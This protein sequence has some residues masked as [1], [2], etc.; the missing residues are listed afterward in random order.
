MEEF[1]ARRPLVY[2]ALLFLASLAAALPIMFVLQGSG[3]MST[4][5]AAAF[6][7]LFVGLVLV[8]LVRNKIHWESSLSGLVLAVPALGYVV[9][10]LAYN[11]LS[12]CPLVSSYELFPA[13]VMGLAPAVLEETVF[14]AATIDALR[15]SGRRGM[16]VL[17]SSALLFALVHLTNA[18]GADLVSVLVQVCY[19]LSIGLVLGAIYLA[20][21][22]FITVV[23]LHAAIDFSSQLFAT[24]PESTPIPAVVAFV[25]LLA[26]EAAYGLWIE[27]NAR[28]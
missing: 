18:V 12:G 28:M 11:A 2:G 19:S 4:D 24:H 13:I 14:R 17:V 10:N 22:D 8:V 9:W 3:R 20:S 16:Q 5:L 21:N 27:K 6:A 15:R 26:V 7:R 23:L 25:V 1:S